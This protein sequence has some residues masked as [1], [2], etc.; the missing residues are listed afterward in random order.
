[1]FAIS[2]ANSLPE[3]KDGNIRDTAAVTFCINSDESN[4][5]EEAVFGN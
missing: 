1:M 5:E 3:L 4:A 2:T